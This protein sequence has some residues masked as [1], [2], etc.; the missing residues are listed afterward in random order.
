M[1]KSTLLKPLITEQKKLITLLLIISASIPVFHNFGGLRFEQLLFLLVIPFTTQTSEDL[2]GPA[3]FIVGAILFFFIY[4]LTHIYTSFYLAICFSVFSGI[5][6]L[7][8]YP[9]K[10]SVLLAVITAPVVKYLLSIFSFPIRLKITEF[11]GGL[12]NFIYNDIEISGNSIYKYGNEFTVAEE[13]LG[14][15]MISTSLV[16]S[17]FIIALF[18]KK[19]KQKPG[20]SLSVTI[21]TLTLFLV[22]ISNLSRIVLTVIFEVYPGTIFHDLIGIITIVI[23]CFIPIIIITF[24]L[25]GLYINNHTNNSSHSKFNPILY[26]L[27]LLTIGSNVI[28]SNSLQPSLSTSEINIEGFNKSLSKDGVLKFENGDHLIYIKPPSFTLGSDHS[29][30]ICWKGAGYKIKNESYI[31]IDN[32]D[33]LSFELIKNNDHLYS[34]WWY[35]N[36]ETNTISQLNWR[37][38]TIKGEAPFYLINITGTSEESVLKASKDFLNKQIIDSSHQRI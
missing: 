4:Y 8:F 20:I 36:G 5:Y 11:A 18:S 30:F 15:N 21:L 29:P 35:S 22:V 32:H 33:A 16:F 31:N 27:L 19:H 25:R 7:G 6:Y 12:L 1:I 10:L 2:K 23:N 38:A 3:I 13:C 14:L 17:I 24:L 9:T 26:I 28:Y 34:V 37:L